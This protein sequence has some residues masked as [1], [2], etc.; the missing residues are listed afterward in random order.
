MKTTILT[1][2]FSILLNG[3]TFAQDS[4]SK[5]EPYW[6]CEANELIH[7]DLRRGETGFSCWAQCF[8]PPDLYDGPPDE[9]RFNGCPDQV[10]SDNLARDENRCEASLGPVTPCLSA[11]SG[12]GTSNADKALI[13]GGVAIAAVAAYH[14][15]APEMSEGLNVR[16]VAN[17]AYRDGL[18]VSVAG[19]KGN[20]RN[21][22]FSAMS[23]N[24]GE[25]WTKPY[26]RVQWAWA[27]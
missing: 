10:P 11:S 4:G 5:F 16:P 6:H 3:V 25:G 14:F 23:A 9:E 7:P 12:G 2:L 20:W 19:L 17:L 1:I 15:L 18:A 26:A 8:Q 21:V 13:A 24:A 27:F 22:E